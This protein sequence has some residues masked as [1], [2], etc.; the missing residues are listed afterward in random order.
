MLGASREV[1]N[2]SSLVSLS[3]CRRK[4]NVKFFTYFTV[5]VASLI[6][7]QLVMAEQVV[8]WQVDFQEAASPVME[9]FK[10][11]HDQLLYIVF[12][13]SAFV[14][15]LLAYVIFRFNSKRNPSPSTTS[16][17]TL[18]EIVWTAVPVII[19]I[20]VLIPSL[21]TLY[22]SDEVPEAD[23]TLK[24]IGY[25]WYWGYEYPDHGGIAFES[26]M[27]QDEDIKP[28]QKRLLSVDNPVYLPV[29]K[30]IRIQ[31]T[32]ADVIHAWAV[33]SM[34]V[35]KD[36]VPGR[37]NETWVRINKPGTYYGQCSELCGVNHGF[38]PIEI[39]AVEEEEFN[40]WVAKAKEE[41]AG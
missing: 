30:N 38:M 40:E 13:V 2:L 5:F 31:I 9:H 27:I 35:K 24:V 39:R 23:M 8:N 20:A 41:F 12:G 15:V 29:N 25:Q 36:A 21:R 6:L 34:A 32:A 33:P 37:L 16:H 19:L 28:G 18:L 4:L 17:N 11:F 26:N 7:P 10:V 3:I 22:F 1:E 14:M